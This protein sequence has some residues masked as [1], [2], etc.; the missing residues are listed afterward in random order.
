M[1]AHPAMLLTLASH[2]IAC[3]A[4]SSAAPARAQW[5]PWQWSCDPG[6]GGG[7]VERESSPRSLGRP[8]QQVNQPRCKPTERMHDAGPPPRALSRC[9]SPQRPST[10]ACIRL[11][12]GCLCALYRKA[13]PSGD[14]IHIRHVLFRWNAKKN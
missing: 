11:L 12:D 9:K 5:L 10:A 4:G 6:C 1:P 3:G 14:F 7:L 2:C 8:L 13:G